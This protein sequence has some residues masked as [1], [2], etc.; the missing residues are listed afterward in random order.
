MDTK[1]IFKYLKK[2]PGKWLLPVIAVIWVAGALLRSRWTGVNVI[3]YCIILTIAIVALWLL[4]LLMKWIPSQKKSKDEGAEGV[5]VAGLEERLVK[6]SESSKDV[7]WFLAVGPS[8]SGKTTMLRNSELDF[9]YIDS[10]Q[11]KP[12]SL[13]IEKTRNCDLFLTKEAVILD[14]SGRYVDFCSEAQV[15]AEKEARRGLASRK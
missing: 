5:P 8:G 11:E 6:A 1:F 9:S 2:L 12:I 10:L 7:P 3:N 15:K 14:T 4:Y 13:G